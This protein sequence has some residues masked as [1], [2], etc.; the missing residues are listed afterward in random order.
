M[1]ATVI[2]SP[3][4]SSLSTQVY[5]FAILSARRK[6]YITTNREPVTQIGRRGFGLM[7]HAG[8]SL[9]NVLACDLE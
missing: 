9:V 3:S 8:P 1:T 2:K 4:N 7:K 6:S 5:V